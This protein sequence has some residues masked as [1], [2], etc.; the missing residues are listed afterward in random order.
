MRAGPV[1]I[2]AEP[3]LYGFCAIG[4]VPAQDTVPNL[5]PRLL[6]FH[7]RNELPVPSLAFH[8]GRK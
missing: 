3:F 7:F 5:I 2:P 8:E 6:K 4:R 1:I